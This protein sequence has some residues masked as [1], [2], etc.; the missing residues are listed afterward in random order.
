MANITKLLKQALKLHEEGKE[1]KSNAKCEKV[2]KKATD[3]RNIGRAY[4]IMAHNAGIIN[5]KEKEIAYAKKAVIAD[6]CTENL[7]LLAQCLED[8][9][10]VLKE[11]GQV[12][13]AEERYKEI[14]ALLPNDIRA[15]TRLGSLCYQ[16]NRR[17]YAEHCY[18]RVLGIE[19]EKAAVTMYHIVQNKKFKKNSDPDLEFMKKSLAFMTKREDLVYL[20]SSLG[21]AYED[22]QVY[23][24]AFSHYQKA[25]F[26]REEGE[27]S[28]KD[29]TNHFKVI[30]EYFTPSLFNEHD[31]EGNHSFTPIFIVGM[32]RSGTTLIEQILA[33]HPDVDGAGEL[34]FI[35]RLP[36]G[37]G[38]F[39]GN[40][41]IDK[42]TEYGNTYMELI[43]H[44]Y[45][46]SRRVVDKMPQNF[47]YAGLIKL[48]LPNAK[49]IHCTRSPE[50]TCWSIFKTHFVG[51]HPY[52]WDLK[53]LGLYYRD[54]A[55]LMEHYEDVLPDPIHTA[56]YEAM[57]TNTEAEIRKLLKFCDLDWHEGCLDFH[58][59]RRSVRTASAGQVTQPVY[60]SSIG[61][62]KNYR[63]KLKP[64]TDALKGVKR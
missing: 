38:M 37:K 43:R 54:Y 40:V 29:C 45:H 30:K 49:I 61:A 33:S 46:D 57:V 17:D 8:I 16:T 3:Q 24:N 50:D 26:I 44:K 28:A 42:L 55:D 34:D 10:E 21:R 41:N 19:P 15:W 48:I 39:P 14:L 63:S 27:W 2:L 18:R 60:T 25:N 5:D 1:D 12:K 31:G 56:N 23:N 64:L 59:T 7:H 32:P 22:L 9:A 62:W 20:H 58:K 6:Q 35:P 4:N 52:S 47:I 11:R 51:K 53:N 13:E 36:S